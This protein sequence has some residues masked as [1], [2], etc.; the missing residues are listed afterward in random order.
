MMGP[1]VISGVI[2]FLCHLPLGYYGVEAISHWHLV[3]KYAGILL[4]PPLSHNIQV[5][6]Q[7]AGPWVW[8]L[9]FSNHPI[10]GNH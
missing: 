4:G 9:K 2:R 6:E 10:Q 1:G 5:G 3:K 8:S 7:F